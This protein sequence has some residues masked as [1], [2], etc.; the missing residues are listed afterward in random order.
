MR[1]FP[2]KLHLNGAP[3]ATIRRPR[4]GGAGRWPVNRGVGLLDA[5]IAMAILA[6]GI[7][8]MTRLQGRMVAQATETQHRSIAMQLSDELLN[9]A[10]VDTANAA[11]YT[12]PAVGACGNATAKA[13]AA[14]WAARSVAALPGAPTAGA[15]LDV[16]TG[17]M[18]VTLTWTGKESQDPR[19]LVATTDVRP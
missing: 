2:T 11:C 17:R 12:V 10:L 7:L 9:S 6:F 14:D 1:Q 18:T 5:L 13:R 19:T 15:V 4:R 3:A 16:A 8:G